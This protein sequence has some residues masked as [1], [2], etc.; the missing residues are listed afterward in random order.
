MH[1]NKAVSQL[2]KS[3][4]L[5]SGKTGCRQLSKLFEQRLIDL[6]EVE[7]GFALHSLFQFGG[8][9]IQQARIDVNRHEI[10]TDVVLLDLH[11][12]EEE[13]FLVLLDMLC[14]NV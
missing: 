3:L 10:V 6:A 2:N 13:R 9:F 12:A 11:R 7:A 4:F 8:Y 14:I 5:I 1:S